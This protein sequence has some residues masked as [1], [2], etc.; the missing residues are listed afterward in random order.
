MSI[1]IIGSSSIW[2]MYITHFLN[3]CNKSIAANIRD[4][5][6]YKLS[7]VKTPTL[8]NSSQLQL[9]GTLAKTRPRIKICFGDR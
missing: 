6:F 2:Q 1:F 7:A 5:L 9:E 4:S 8:L 3:Y